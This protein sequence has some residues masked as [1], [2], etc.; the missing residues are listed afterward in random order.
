MIF[1]GEKDAEDPIEENAT[2]DFIGQHR[3]IIKQ[4]HDNS[5]PGGG[6]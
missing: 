2:L 4:S 3:Q 5:K 1:F 6:K